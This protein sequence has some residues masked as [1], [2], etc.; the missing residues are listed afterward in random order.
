MSGNLLL[1]DLQC[2]GNNISSL[3]LPPE[4]PTARDNKMTYLIISNNPI[5]SVDVT[6]FTNLSSLQCNYCNLDELDVTNNKNLTR[7]Y[8]WNN[9]LTDLDLSN[10][11]KLSDFRCSNN[12]FGE[13]CSVKVIISPL[14]T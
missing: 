5:G 4:Q 1:K 9:N 14:S 12:P 3:I 11:T 7:L 8:C 10:N 6:Y 2:N 13:M